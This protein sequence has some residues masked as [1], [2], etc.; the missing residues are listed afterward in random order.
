MNRMIWPQD[1]YT[2]RLG[3]AA[4]LLCIIQPSVEGYENPEAHSREVEVVVQE[5]QSHHHLILRLIGENL[6]SFNLEEKTEMKAGSISFPVSQSSEDP[7]VDK[8]L[9]QKPT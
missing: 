2:T 6:F 9:A 4:D 3:R 5:P 8:K 7:R 1:H